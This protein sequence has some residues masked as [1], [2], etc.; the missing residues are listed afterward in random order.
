MSINSSSSR[1]NIIRSNTNCYHC[2]VFKFSFSTFSK[3]GYGMAWKRTSFKMWS[4]VLIYAQTHT[5]AHTRWADEKTHGKIFISSKFYVLNG[6]CM[7]LF[8][9]R[10]K[11]VSDREWE[12]DEVWSVWGWAIIA[13]YQHYGPLFDGHTMSPDC[14]TEFRLLKAHYMNYELN[15]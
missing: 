9:W 11:F 4:N 6:I 3:Y 10:R 14:R 5:H 13:I 7:K 12:M 2:I 8:R 15:N 1:N